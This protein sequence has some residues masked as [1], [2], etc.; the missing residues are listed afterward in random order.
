MIVPETAQYLQHFHLRELPFTL[1]PN[2][3]FY[4]GLSAHQSA[5]NVLLVSLYNNEGFIKVVGEVGTG[6]TLLCRKLLNQ[7]EGQFFTAYILNPNLTPVGFFKNFA[8]E[9][10]LE[11]KSRS[12]QQLLKKITEKLMSLYK[13]G[14]RVVLIIVTASTRSCRKRKLD[15]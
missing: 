12:Q 4:C 2:T 6:K 5:L 15:Y 14:E 13:S 7:L 3:E 9:L 1:T 11:V 10:G 8:H